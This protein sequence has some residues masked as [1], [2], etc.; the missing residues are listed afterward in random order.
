MKSHAPALLLLAA[1]GSLVPLRPARAQ[2]LWSIPPATRGLTIPGGEIA[3]DA[4]ATSVE[5]NPGQLGLLEATSTALVVNLWPDQTTREGRGGGLFYA[6]PLLLRGLSLG[7]GLEWL[8]PSMA[9]LP[10]DYGKLAVAG[11]FRLGRS[12]GF[13]VLWE[14]LIRSR[15][16][17]TSSL[18]LG[19]GWRPH[20][21]VAVG[22]AGRDLLRPRPEPG[23]PRLPRE[24]DTEVA[25]RPLGTPRLEVAAGLRLLDGTGPADSTDTVRFSPHARL[26]LG[27]LRG[28]SLFAELD[29]PRAQLAVLGSDGVR[30]PL[31]EYRGL[32]GL[33]ASF[34][35]L[36][37][38]GGALASA[39]RGAGGTS[40]P[41]APG[42]SLVV[43]S[44]FNR[45]PSVVSVSHVARVKLGGLEGDRSFI[46]TV[47]ALRRLADDPSVGGLLLQLDRLDLGYGRIEE[48]RAVLVDI[49]RVKPVF[50]WLSS[51]TTGEYY[52]ASAATTIAIHPA[53]DLFLG[54]LAS[55]V[56]FFKN[57]LDQLGVGVDLVRIAE[58]KGAMEPFVFANQSQPVRDNRNELLDDLYGRLKEGISRSRASKGIDAQRIGTLFDR[59]LFSAAE[60][61]DLGLVDEV[62]D[63][64]QMEKIVQARFGRR[65][66]VR[67]ADFGRRETGRWRPRRVA[68][69]LVDGAITDGR[70]RGIPSPVQGAVAWADPILDALAAARGDASVGAVV[71]RVNSPGG[72]AFASDRIAREVARL[73]E[74]RKPVVV[75]MGDT[76]ASGGYYVAAPA[77]TIFASPSVVTGSIGIYAFK[78]DLA[79]L[80]GK[81]GITTE[82][83]TRGGRAD[84]YS[85][86]RPWREDERAAVNARIRNHYDQFLKTVAG[87]RKERGVDEKRADDL[88]RGRVFTGAQARR[89]GLVDE[90]GGIATAIEEAARRGRVPMGPGN[91]PEMVL[92]PS[93]PTDPLE[94][95][96]ALRRL[97]QVAGEAG[98]VGDGAGLAG[99]EGVTASGGITSAAEAGA[100]AAAA[101]ATFV[102]RY[103][104]AAARLLLPVL[105]GEPGDIQARLPY[106]LEIR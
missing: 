98:D 8:R 101:G 45:K 9:T 10:S 50:V 103:G 44:F 22:I 35:R 31:T 106:D 54:G 92:L 12:L 32:L 66:A 5:T 2:D 3:G 63:E 89:L 77:D 1:A 25:V 68:V 41:R 15:Y 13:G 76:A 93:T 49:N 4:D 79:S 95:L 20:P 104:R 52:L 60:A 84:L 85:L 46:E 55:T 70:P 30:R 27:L 81:L 11:G 80:V 38:G 53:G 73:R 42:A 69:I 33:T 86:Y 65:I 17:G 34:D 88:G 97:V 56:T 58:Y 67:D 83:T 64:R 74:A 47:V 72:S 36:V 96:L 102:A 26:S 43:Q 94:T 14:R 29:S 61:K 24:L 48:L 28:L 51:P 105:L 37:V 6:T 21:L 40:S 99:A 23:G 7:V 16:G 75:S 19:L 71:L 82:T 90:L 57:A 39:H 100:A 91:L 78:L 18:G 87:G 62:G 59:G